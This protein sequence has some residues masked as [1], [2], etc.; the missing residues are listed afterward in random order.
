[1]RDAGA[2]SGLTFAVGAFALWGLIPI[3]F[4]T[5]EEVPPL[6]VLGHRVF[7]SSLLLVCFLTFRHKLKGIIELIKS[8]RI[9]GWLVLSSLF[10]AG[11]WLC[12]IWG[13]TNDRILETS[14]GY[15]INPL[16]SVFFGYC[17]LGERLT[18]Y[19]MLAVLIAAAAV[20]MQMFLLGK[21]PWVA[22]VLALCFAFYGLIRKRINVDATTGLAIETL[23][24]MP[25][26][27][28]YF[29]WLMGND[30]H[31]F[32]FSDPD[33][34]VLLALAGFVT[35]I[36]LVFFNMATQKLSLTVLGIMQYLAPSISFLVG[37]TI[38]NE[39]L[40]VVQMATFGLI[41]L[42]LAIFTLDGLFR[43]KRQSDRLETPV[44]E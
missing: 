31:A 7:W 12:F 35:T 4:K 32:R 39:P 11:N 37:V 34:S 16:I 10:I 29:L 2:Q 36:P 17:F 3:Y 28:F 6:E 23:L 42:A 14:L 8:P 26:V 33:T 44:T 19:Q 9:L 22:F 21:L 25:P 24:L 30:L 43:H 15:Y 20:S 18:R 5:L 40:G 41:W 38:Y 1:M 27:A 13:V